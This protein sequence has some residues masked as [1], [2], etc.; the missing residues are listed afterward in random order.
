M[1][2]FAQFFNRPCGRSL[3]PIPEGS[4]CSGAPIEID[5]ETTTI[6][7]RGGLWI[8]FVTGFFIT[9]ASYGAL[10]VT[11]S[12]VDG[13]PPTES[14]CW[15]AGFAWSLIFCCAALSVLWLATDIIICS[16]GKMLSNSDKNVLESLFVAGCVGSLSTSSML[17]HWILEDSFRWELGLMGF[18]L[19]WL[20]WFLPKCTAKHSDEELP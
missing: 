19:F 16:F 1:M 14:F 20:H 15:L 18:V 10:A 7:A 12:L 6:L 5:H 2:I 13:G 17:L 11:I 4:S 3:E 9:L 8:G